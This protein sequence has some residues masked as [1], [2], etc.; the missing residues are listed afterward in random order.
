LWDVTQ[1]QEPR[2][3]MLLGTSFQDIKKSRTRYGH[4][5]Y[6]GP[7]DEYFEHK[8]GH[9]PYRSLQ[10]DLERYGPEALRHSAH[11]GF[12]Q[13]YLQINYADD[14]PYTRTVEVKHITGQQ[15]GHSTVV[16]EYPQEHVPGKNELYYPIPTQATTILAHEY[17]LLA[18]AEVRTT[19]LGRMAL[20]RYINM[21]QIVW[22]A[23]C[24]SASLT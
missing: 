3:E 4:V 14:V 7:L 9:L 21:D 18:Q 19:F 10:F 16:R 8:L 13:P 20:Y 2:N 5:V 1:R 6:T 17:G 15:T 11:P 24:K 12:A 22:E 23:L